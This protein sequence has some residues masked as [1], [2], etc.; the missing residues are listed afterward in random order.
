MYLF[1]EKGLKGGISYVCKRYSKANNKY[2]KNYDPT[3]PSKHITYLAE[4]NL[5]GWA[6]SGYLLYGKFKWLKF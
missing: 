6:M 5:Y 4:N 1:V 2:M 3:K